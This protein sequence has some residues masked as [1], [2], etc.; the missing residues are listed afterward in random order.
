MKTQIEIAEKVTL[1][2]YG[3]TGRPG[4]KRNRNEDWQRGFKLGEDQ[5]DAE[6]PK[7]T[8]EHPL[9]QEWIRI[10]KPYPL[11]ASYKELKLG[12]SC[13]RLR[14]TFSQN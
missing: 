12:W 13:A 1:A 3:R 2:L 10:G 5:G 7:G 9:T 11:P 14:M 6:F 8:T 4:A